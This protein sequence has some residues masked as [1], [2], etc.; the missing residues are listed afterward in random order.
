MQGVERVQADEAEADGA[1]GPFGEGLE[2]CEI[3]AAP[4]AV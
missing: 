2:V 3:A 1:M 4:V